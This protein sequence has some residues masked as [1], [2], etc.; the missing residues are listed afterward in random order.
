MVDIWMA[1]L[2][3]DQDMQPRIIPNLAGAWEGKG[4]R[5]CMWEPSPHAAQTLTASW[6]LPP[7]GQ[8]FRIN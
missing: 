5:V 4:A 7:H 2:R 1:E 8:C 6:V 3:R